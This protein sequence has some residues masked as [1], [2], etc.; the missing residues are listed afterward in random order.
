MFSYEFEVQYEYEN[1]GKLVLP[2]P[3]FQFTL[4]M[5]PVNEFFELYL[6]VHVIG[7]KFRNNLR[8]FFE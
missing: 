2:I 1:I 3:M 6:F 7:R 4:V 5:V 8:G